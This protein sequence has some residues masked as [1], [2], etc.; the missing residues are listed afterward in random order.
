MKRQW[1]II[2]ALSVVLSMA[3]PVQAQDALRD[4]LT[5]YVTDWD[6]NSP[7]LGYY[8]YKFT[9]QAS[10]QLWDFALQPLAEPIISGEAYS[11]NVFDMG[12]DMFRIS[13]QPELHAILTVSKGDSHFP[14]KGTEFQHRKLNA[15]G[16]WELVQ[17][18]LFTT[19]AD[20]S[21]IGVEAYYDGGELHI[22]W[23]EDNDAA[24]PKSM[25]CEI[26]DQAY[27]INA[28]GTLTAKGTKTLVHSRTLNWSGNRGGLGGIAGL[29]VCDYTGDG[30]LDFIV[31]QMFY[32]DSPSGASIQLIERLSADQWSGTFQELWY[33]QPGHGAEAVH[34]CDVDGDAN[35]DLVITSGSSLPWSTVVHFEKEGNQLVEKGIVIECAAEIEFWE[36]EL[37]IGH[38]FGLYVDSPEP[39]MVMDWEIMQ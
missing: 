6:N 5:V 8:I 4:G 23:V 33:G 38:I 29:T 27:T 31:G 18:P 15:A 24:G 17:P 26:Y 1:F 3:V 28:D 30:R 36:P 13:G 7:S 16:E 21:P 34:Y 11:G 20:V 32:G 35:L 12:M 10:T 19:P 37:S 39:T 14:S 22:A 2:V 25:K 9:F